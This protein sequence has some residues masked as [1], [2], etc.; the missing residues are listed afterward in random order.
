MLK[1]GIIGASGYT[2]AETVKEF[3][4]ITNNYSAEYRSAAGAIV[5]AVTKSGTNNFHGSLFEFLRNDNFDAT[6]RLAGRKPDDLRQEE[7]RQDL[8]SV[9]EADDVADPG[10]AERDHAA[11]GGAGDDAGDRYLVERR[12][13]RGL[14]DQRS[15]A[16]LCWY[17]AARR[18]V[19]RQ[20]L[21]PARLVRA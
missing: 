3:Q 19:G 7:P 4:V 6:E 13:Q 1:V 11:G 2:G 10:E 20:D 21:G 9:L 8:L 15:R 12:R 18:C 14:V 16:A 5:S 17:V